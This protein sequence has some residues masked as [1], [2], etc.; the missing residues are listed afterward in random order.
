[1]DYFFQGIFDVGGVYQK[2]SNNQKTC[3]SAKEF[4]KKNSEK[5]FWP[6]L[7]RFSIDRLAHHY[8]A[9][10]PRVI[11]EATRIYDYVVDLNSSL[12]NTG[13]HKTLSFLTSDRGHKPV[14]EGFVDFSQFKK[15][16]EPGY[17]FYATN[18]TLL[19][20]Y[21]EGLHAMIMKSSATPMLARVKKK[22]SEFLGFDFK[23][24]VWKLIQLPP[25]FSYQNGVK[26]LKGFLDILPTDLMFAVE[27]RHNGP[28]T[29]AANSDTKIWC[30]QGTCPQS[31][32]LRD[33]AWNVR[34]HQRHGYG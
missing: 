31:P 27:F 12:Q 20:L 8:G 9:E 29:S 2:T 32:T 17:K 7:V 26:N 21:Y 34:L 3:D 15:F 24:E 5:R 14:P 16:L 23:Y 33:Q 25:S 6:L 28:P 18:Q 10:D 11:A 30:L 13:K 4:I 22:G 1:M 19:G